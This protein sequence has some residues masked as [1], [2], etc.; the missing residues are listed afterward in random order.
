MGGH[1]GG[2]H[3]GGFYGGYRPGWGYRRGVPLFSWAPRF[4]GWRRPYAVPVYGPGFGCCCGTLLLG[5]IAVLALPLGLLF[6]KR[7]IK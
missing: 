5:M 7:Y 4:W 1:Y 3:R 2:G 6:G